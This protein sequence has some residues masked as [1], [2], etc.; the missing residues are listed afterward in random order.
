MLSARGRLWQE[1]D[2]DPLTEAVAKCI[3]MSLGTAVWSPAIGVSDMLL[4]EED[5]TGL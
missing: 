1:L 4:L 2:E 5:V 3:I